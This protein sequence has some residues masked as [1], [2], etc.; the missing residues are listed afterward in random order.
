MDWLRPHSDVNSPRR[1]VSASKLPSKLAYDPASLIE[2]IGDG[3]ALV[4]ATGEILWMT[5]RL[6]GKDP[7]AMRIFADACRDAIKE[8]ATLTRRRKRVSHA[9]S[10]WE[11]EIVVLGEDRALGVFFDCAL[12]Q[13]F[14]QFIDSVDAAGGELL[15]LD[16]QI[17]NPLNVGERLALL[18]RKVVDTMERVFSESAFEVRLRNRQT[19]Q[20]ELVIGRGIEPLRIGE[21]IFAR[22]HGNGVCGL[23]AS[24]GES[25]VCNNPD[26][27][28]Y[29]RNG[30]PGARSALTVPLLLQERVIG[31]LNVESMEKDRFTEEHRLALETYGRYVAMALNIL[32]ML[33]VERY[34]TSERISGMV[35]DEVAIP[36]QR[37][38]NA[39]TDVAAGRLTG[40]ESLENALVSLETRLKTATAGPRTVLGI[41]RV[42]VDG[43]KDPIVSGKRVLV[44]DDDASVRETIQALL[45][46]CGA[47]AES[48]GDGTSALEIVTRSTHEGRP[49]DLVISDIRLPDHNGYDVFRGTKACSA[50]TTV[51]LMTGFGYDPNHSIV[52]SSQEGLSCVL[53]KPFQ[54]EQ[55]FEEVRRALAPR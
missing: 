51:I 29:Y 17:V 32:D 24:T 28:P 23:V 8:R 40:H 5:E 44:V 9:D 25:Y 14:T 38:R 36:L 54:A 7:A 19:A 42:V 35:R 33:I 16:A 46:D 15:D 26:N 3:V 6:A 43:A 48:C 4:D 10:S 13:R 12:R 49:F 41:D 47:L 34:T 21:A 39:A 52:R 22:P 50:N 55:L 30:L 1:A 45:Q 2:A 31:V 37:V 18:E 11:V 27:D 53:F 20:L